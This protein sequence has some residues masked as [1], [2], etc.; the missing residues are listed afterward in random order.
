MQGILGR[1][2]ASA[3]VVAGQT[4]AESTVYDNQAQVMNYDLVLTTTY[5]IPLIFPISNFLLSR[6]M[7]SQTRVIQVT[8]RAPIEQPLP[9]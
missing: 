7:G 2:I 4:R 9:Q 1:V 6:P 8:V 3:R 5:P